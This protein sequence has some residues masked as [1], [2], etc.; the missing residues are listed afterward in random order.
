MQKERRKWSFGGLIV[1]CLLFFWGGGG[2]LQ[3]NGEWV[4]GMEQREWKMRRRFKI[5]RE[6]KEKTRPK[7]KTRERYRKTG[8]MISLS[9]SCSPFSDE[10]PKPPSF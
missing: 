10:D 6:L 3:E 5:G 8:Q 2:N 9:P 4:N 7:K 1:D